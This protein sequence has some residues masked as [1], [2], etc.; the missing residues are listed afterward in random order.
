M[1]WHI[2]DINPA[3]LPRCLQDGID[4]C[5]TAHAI[6]EGGDA[7]VT[8]HNGLDKGKILIPTEGSSGITCEGIAWRAGIDQEIARH[9]YSLQRAAWAAKGYLVWAV[10]VVDQSTPGAIDL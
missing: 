8:F 3:P 4:H 7:T 9:I 2:S 6:V 1:L 5:L 10:Q